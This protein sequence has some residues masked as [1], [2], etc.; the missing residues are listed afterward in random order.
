MRHVPIV[1]S[2]AVLA[3]AVEESTIFAP[4]HARLAE[5]RSNAKAFPIDKPVKIPVPLGLPP[6]P[7]PPD[8]PP[9]AETIALGR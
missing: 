1:L 4:P 9:T 6:V 2:L 7:I 5:A 8:N 3:A